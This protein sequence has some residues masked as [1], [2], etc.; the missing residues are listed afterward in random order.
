MDEIK[1]TTALE[2][3]VGAAAE[4]SQSNMYTGSIADPGPEINR[5]IK[6]DTLCHRRWQSGL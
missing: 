2:P 4:Q 1:K 5:K 3:A 6:K